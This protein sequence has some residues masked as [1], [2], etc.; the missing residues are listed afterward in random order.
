MVFVQNISENEDLLSYPKVAI[1]NEIFMENYGSFSVN[2][3]CFTR[4]R[5]AQFEHMSYFFLT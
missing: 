4:S 3:T 5:G 1:K 2:T